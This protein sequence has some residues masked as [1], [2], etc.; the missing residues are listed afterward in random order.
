VMFNKSYE[1]TRCRAKFSQDDVQAANDRSHA[2][3]S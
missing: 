1:C 3:A 2:P